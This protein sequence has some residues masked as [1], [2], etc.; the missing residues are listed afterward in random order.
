MFIGILREKLVAEK[1]L[2]LDF[3][4]P[5]GAKPISVTKSLLPHA[6]V[7]C[8][9]SQEEKTLVKLVKLEESKGPVAQPPMLS[10][11]LFGLE[12]TRVHHLL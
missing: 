7:G 10:P 1:L 6:L 2:F 4:F 5:H 12:L 3:M 11:V 9:I 8:V